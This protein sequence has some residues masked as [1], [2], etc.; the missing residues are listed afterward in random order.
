M[1]TPEHRTFLTNEIQRE[2]DTQYILE[3]TDPDENN[4]LVCASPV[5]VTHTANKTRAVL[6]YTHRR[7]FIDVA[8]CT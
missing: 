7:T 3:R 1:L 2:M 4:T 5:F 8:T 6:N